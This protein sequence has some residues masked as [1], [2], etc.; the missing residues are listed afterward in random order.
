M[1]GAGGHQAGDVYVAGG[2]HATVRIE[3]A[4]AVPNGMYGIQ[5]DHGVSAPTQIGMVS[6][7]SGKG[8]W[9]GPTTLPRGAATV[10]LV[11]ISGNVVCSAFVGDAATP[12]T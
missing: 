10:S 6:V 5:V 12:A 4:Y 8:E 3:V 7:M 2:R 1:I 11:D 9:S